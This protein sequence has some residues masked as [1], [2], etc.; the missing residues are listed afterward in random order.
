MIQ[1]RAILR[2]GLVSAH[3]GSCLTLKDLTEGF[4]WQGEHRRFQPKP[5]LPGGGLAVLALVEVAGL[6]MHRHVL[7]SHLELAAIVRARNQLERT[8]RPV[9]GELRHRAA[10]VAPR[11]VL[12]YEEVADH[13]LERA[14]PLQLL[15]VG[16]L[17]ADRAGR[18]GG[19]CFLQDPN[20]ASWMSRFMV[21]GSRCRVPDSGFR[22]QG[23]GFR[24]RGSG[25]AR[26]VA[27]T[28]SLRASAGGLVHEHQ[29]DAARAGLLI[30]LTLHQPLGIHGCSLRPPTGNLLASKSRQKN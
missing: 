7:A 5:A 8:G 28:V 23:S 15:F 13:G 30:R 16:F 14:D 3:G 1:S 11:R 19:R 2:K 24:V 18:L 22:V 25:F 29:A 4:T 20:V 27:E 21:R 17:F 9:C 10:P 6:R 26:T 12:S